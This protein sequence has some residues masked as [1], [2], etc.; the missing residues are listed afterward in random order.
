MLKAFCL[1]FRAFKRDWHPFKI[2]AAQ[3]KESQDAG[4]E[5]VVY[6]PYLD[7]RHYYVAAAADRIIAPPGAQFDVL[8]L[9]TEVIFLKDALQQIGVQVDV[10]QISPYKTAMD[11]LQHAD[12][13]PEYQAQLDWLL[14]DQFDMITAGMATGRGLSQEKMKAIID[15]APIFAESAL[16]KGLLDILAYEDELAEL[17][18]SDKKG[19]QAV[20][21]ETKDSAGVGKERGRC[22]P[23]SDPKNLATGSKAAA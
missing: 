10:V 4:K 11:M 15:E 9:H 23:K 3:S 7:L 16:E 14:D 8:G 5:V 13:T 21:D 20:G 2:Y 17:L 12:I 1:S 18:G 22:G 19:Q 6:T